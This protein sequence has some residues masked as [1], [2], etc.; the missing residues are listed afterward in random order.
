ME[1]GGLRWGWWWYSEHS[2]KLFRYPRTQLLARTSSVIASVNVS[3]ANAREHNPPSSSVLM[4][5]VVSVGV[6]GGCS[7]RI[8]KPRCN[9]DI[10]LSARNRYCVIHRS[11]TQAMGAGGCQLVAAEFQ[12]QHKYVVRAGI[13]AVSWLLSWRPAAVV[14]TQNDARTE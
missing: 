2:R 12:T 7:G 8:L 10:E 5:G 1:G 4:G 13:A 14:D 3:M 9:N 11:Q 6:G